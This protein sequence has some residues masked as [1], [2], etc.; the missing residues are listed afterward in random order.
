M[1]DRPLGKYRATIIAALGLFPVVTTAG[2]CVPTTSSLAK[3]VTIGLIGG[4]GLLKSKLPALAVLREEIV[5]TPHGRVFLRC[6][7]IATGVTLVFVQRHDARV[8]REY[9]QPADINYPA[10]ALALKAKVREGGRRGPRAP[11]RP[12]GAFTFVPATPSR[13]YPPACSPC[14]RR[15]PR[16]TSWASAPWAP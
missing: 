7:T 14:P 16:T 12:A 3:M 15:R 10:V 8:T 13:S 2:F 4:S 11:F 5:D 6:G 1:T 9:T